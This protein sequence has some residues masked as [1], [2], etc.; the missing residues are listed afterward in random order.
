MI[1]L[2]SDQN[3]KDRDYLQHHRHFVDIDGSACQKPLMVNHD[4]Q[5]CGDSNY[6]S[7][8]YVEPLST[9]SP[10]TYATSSKSSTPVSN[11]GYPFL[12][13]PTIQYP[14]A[15][16]MHTAKESA[17]PHDNPRYFRLQGDSSHSSLEKDPFYFS[18]GRPPRMYDANDNTGR[19]SELSHASYSSQSSA[20]SQQY[21][22]KQA[23]RV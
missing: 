12:S 18:S 17:A 19:N 5:A 4:T 7:R 16:D 1:S 8:L 10:L 3:L 9:I 6:S 13:N 2:I 15:P 21:I 23:T 11:V 14:G 22:S 20:P